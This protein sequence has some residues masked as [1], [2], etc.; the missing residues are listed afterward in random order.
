LALQIP[1]DWNFLF[2]SETVPHGHLFL[3]PPCTVNLT[4]TELAH[5]ARAAN[6][7]GIS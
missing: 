6:A 1:L 5:Q 2:F 7:R 3:M 4:G